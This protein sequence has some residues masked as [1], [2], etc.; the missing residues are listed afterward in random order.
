MPNP[1]TNPR[2]IM[3]ASEPMDMQS[4]QE[5]ID[6]HP[7]LQLTENLYP[8]D[9]AEI[10]LLESLLAPTIDIRVC[11]F[12]LLELVL[13]G[14]DVPDLLVKFY[15]LFWTYD[16]YRLGN[17]I[18]KRIRKYD[19]SKD[20]S[21]LAW[22][23]TNMR[24]SSALT[25]SRVFL[26]FQYSDAFP[27]T[28]YRTQSPLGTSISRRD[29]PNTASL[30]GNYMRRF[31]ADATLGMIIDHYHSTTHTCH[32][33]DGLFK[34]WGARRQGSPDTDL[35]R[36]LSYICVLDNP[37][38]ELQPPKTRIA[39]RHEELAEAKEALTAQAPRRHELLAFRR[40]CAT[41]ST[42]NA[43]KL[44]RH[45]VADLWEECSHRWEYYAR[46]TPSW[47]N[48]LQAFNAAFNHNRGIVFPNDDLLEA[49]Y[50]AHYRD[51]DEQSAETQAKSIH[52]LLGTDPAS[53]IECFIHDA[54]VPDHLPTKLRLSTE[55]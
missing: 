13:S 55:N 14:Y 30:V 18:E 44:A 23:V 10:S 43:F 9:E 41:S 37:T 26:M 38:L 36:L 7:P 52:T 29:D 6:P 1:E 2:R 54:M 11:Y 49:F 17:S 5:A 15:L 48:R 3:N 4:M 51:F 33:R 47:A 8:K 24:A 34:Y 50:D 42:S 31:G 20:V 45:G 46:N 21:E 19:E 40:R 25:S 28:L 12:W 39:V 16:D 53:W 22:I 27:T 35:I 32:D